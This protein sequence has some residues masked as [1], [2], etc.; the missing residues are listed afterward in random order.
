MNFKYSYSEFEFVATDFTT[1]LTILIVL[2]IFVIMSFTLVYLFKNNAWEGLLKSGFLKGFLSEFD[3]D[4]I[5]RRLEFDIMNN[6]GFT[7]DDDMYDDSIEPEDPSNV[8]T[9]IDNMNDGKE[10]EMV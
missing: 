10:M 3:Q 2:M 8:E 6:Y 9:M 7:G 4:E 1:A 5:G